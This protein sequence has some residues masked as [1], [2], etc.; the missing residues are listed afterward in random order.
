[1]A[2]TPLTDWDSGLL[3][4]FEDPNTCCYGFWCPPCLSCTVSR[5]VGENY[6]LPLCD[7]CVGAI[8]TIYRVP[9]VPPAALAVRVAMRHKYGIKGSICKDIGISCCCPWCSWCQMHRE[10]KYR[11][12]TPHV[13][14]MQSQT[15]V[16]MQ[17]APVMMIPVNPLPPAAVHQTLTVQA[18]K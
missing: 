16:N 11:R 1:M 13:I 6:C 3:D 2:E 15:V 10:L 18:S 8:S 9:L 5:R 7:V 12:K 14:N 17:P 4:C